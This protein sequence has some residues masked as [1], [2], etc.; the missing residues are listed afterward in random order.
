MDMDNWGECFH[1]GKDHIPTCNG[2]CE[3]CQNDKINREDD[4]KEDR[5]LHEEK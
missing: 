1:C 4:I 5:K 2:L 3:E